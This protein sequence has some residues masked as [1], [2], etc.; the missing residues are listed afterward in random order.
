MG[1]SCELML[2]IMYL[3][4]LGGDEPGSRLS[5]DGLS[6]PCG[7]VRASKHASRGPFNLFERRYGLAE[8][9]ERGVG[10]AVERPCIIPL[11]PERDLV[12]L[13]ENASRHGYLL[14]QQC[15]GVF[16]AP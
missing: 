8:I 4:L 15:L 14:A 13:A 7:R 6:P 5:Q 3:G 2:S 11:H 9:V 10:V 1:A 12:S 16:E